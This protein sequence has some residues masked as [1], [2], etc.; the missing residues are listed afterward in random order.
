MAEPGDAVHAGRVAFV[1][2]GYPRL[3]ETFIAQ[4]IAALEQRIGSL[5]KGR[6][7][8]EALLASGKAREALDRIVNAQGRRAK[9]H[10]PASLTKIVKADRAG[11]VT[12]IDGWSVA[13]IARRAGAPSDKGAGIDLL[14]GLGDRVD[15]GRPLFAIHSNDVDDLDAAFALASAGH[16]IA[17][18][19]SRVPEGSAG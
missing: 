11:I 6:E 3:S 14:V 9:P 1:L 19:E 4:E 16:G 18:E 8:A 12:G 17:V 15:A 5:E 13:G 2:K 7:R 10:G